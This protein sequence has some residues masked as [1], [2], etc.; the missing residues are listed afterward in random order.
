[1]YDESFR[2]LLLFSGGAAAYWNLAVFGIGKVLELSSDR[3]LVVKCAS[4]LTL[5]F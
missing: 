5:G 3:L 1:M 2:V 4:I